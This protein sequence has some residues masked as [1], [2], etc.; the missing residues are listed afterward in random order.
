MKTFFSYQKLQL[1]RIFKS[2]PYIAV[3]SL[4]FFTASLFIIGLFL[5]NINLTNKAALTAKTSR[6]ENGSKKYSIG[7]IGDMN[8]PYMDFAISSLEALDT[9][10]FSIDIKLMDL[11]E[12]K[13]ELSK[14][15]I[16]A[17]VIIP[18]GFIESIENG[19]NDKQI[20]YVTSDSQSGFGEIIKNEI[21]VSEETGQISVAE[22]GV[23]DRDFDGKA[24][25]LKAFLI[26]KL[27]PKRTDSRK[28]HLP[29]IGK[30][31]KGA[32]S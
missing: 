30:R 12:A 5:Q 19:Q 18:Q 16:S 15:K 10:K 14:G 23:L 24:V 4:V 17:Y 27:I 32:D 2:F 21:A 8:E 6:N 25:R 26:E 29:T 28:I 7:I 20:I 3:L 31:G 1:K 13:K 11:Q 22:N 9:S